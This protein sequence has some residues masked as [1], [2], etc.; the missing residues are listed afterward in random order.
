MRFIDGF[1]DTDTGI[2]IV[3]LEHLG[4]KFAG[5]AYLHPDDE[6]TAS[7]I[8]GCEYAEIRATMNALKYERKLKKHDYKVIENFIKACNCYNNFNKESL[9]ARVMYRQLNRK[10]KEINDLTKDIERFEGELKELIS[11]REKI[12]EKMKA[13]KENK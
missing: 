7:E 13:K 10:K 4:K 12:M 1:Y 11:R 5:Q 9:S 6:A 2:S 8:V 3:M